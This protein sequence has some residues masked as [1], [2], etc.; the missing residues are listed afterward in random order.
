MNL[1]R[2]EALEERLKDE[3]KSRLLNVSETNNK[4]LQVL[5]TFEESFH[6]RAKSKESNE[7]GPSF[8]LLDQSSSVKQ[9]RN[10]RSCL[11]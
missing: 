9:P 1:A 2:I 11:S 8:P 5:S 3:E 7:G 6:C 10:T 4:I